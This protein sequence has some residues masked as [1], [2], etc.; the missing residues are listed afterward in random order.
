MNHDRRISVFA[1]LSGAVLGVMAMA[2]MLP[3]HADALTREVR[4]VRTPDGF[5][6]TSPPRIERD[7]APGSRTTEQIRIT[8]ESTNAVDVSIRAT[9]FGPTDD[10]RSLGTQVQRSEFG[11]GSWLTP[12]VR[13]LRLAPFERVTLDITIDPPIDAPVG[14]SLG[15]IAVT[16][17]PA[18]GAVGASDDSSSL[19]IDAL[20]QMFLT[21]PGPVRHDLS[22]TKVVTRDAFM[23]GSSRVIT[24]DVGFDNRG[25]VNEHVSG[26]V[27][28]GS[29]FGTRAARVQIDP[30]IILRGSSRTVR[31][32]WRDVPWVGAFTPTVEVRGDDARKITRS[33]DRTIVL[34]WW[35]I[36]A[37]VLAIA[38][39]VLVMWWRRRRAWM[40]YLDDDLDEYP[41]PPYDEDP[42]AR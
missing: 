6:H 42:L 10:P 2:L 5:V 37:I 3:P 36:P 39:P 7:V 30:T 23:F 29:I 40:A 8:N 4:P 15:A 18:S 34:P 27:N 38:L 17:G 25:T 28:V 32:V 19:V 22:I 12:E 20:V 21:V 26:S 11:A 9:D 33:G 13:E 1:Y 31:V 41:V 16:A 24:W 35:V 14:T